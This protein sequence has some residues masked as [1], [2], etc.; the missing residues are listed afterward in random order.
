MANVDPVAS[1]SRTD[2]VQ[3]MM[4]ETQ[5]RISS[6]AA[7]ELSKMAEAQNVNRREMMERLIFAAAR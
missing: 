3:G 4:G 7:R 1:G 2:A 6:E 5:V